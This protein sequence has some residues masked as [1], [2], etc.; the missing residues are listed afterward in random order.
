VPL[1]AGAWEIVRTLWVE[2][3]RGAWHRPPRAPVTRRRHQRA[4]AGVAAGADFVL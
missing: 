2:P 1:L 4:G 3:R